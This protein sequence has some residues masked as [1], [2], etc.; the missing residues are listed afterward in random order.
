M[1]S[2]IAAAL[3]LAL[4]CPALASS[5]P[6]ETCT[7]RVKRDAAVN[8]LSGTR[9]VYIGE[10]MFLGR[11]NQKQILRSCPTGSY[12]RIEGVTYSEGEV[13][14]EI[15]TFTS[16]KRVPSPYQQG[17]RDYR[18]GLCYRARPYS[19]HSPEQKLWER[20]YGAHPTAKITKRNDENCFLRNV[21]EK[22]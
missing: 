20:G 22:H 21:K 1:K 8:E 6:P 17:M 15:D 11:D 2:L 14:P 13:G 18:D 4:A 16:V 5:A 3:L 10:C 7:G 19:D 9:I 12:C